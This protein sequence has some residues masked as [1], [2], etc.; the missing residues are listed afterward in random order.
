MRLY[1]LF[2]FSDNM[3]LSVTIPIVYFILAVLVQGRKNRQTHTYT[4]HSNK[5][6]F[7]LHICNVS[8]PKHCHMRIVNIFYYRRNK[9]NNP[10][11][12]KYTQI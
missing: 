4:T 1:F 6:K 12:Q 3:S 9:K 7:I 5:R 11:R 10:K 2:L 8:R